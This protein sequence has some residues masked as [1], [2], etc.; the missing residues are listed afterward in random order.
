MFGWLTF[1]KSEEGGEGKFVLTTSFL[2][3]NRGGGRL[4][5]GFCRS[6]AVDAGTEGSLEGAIDVEGDAII[7]SVLEGGTWTAGSG[8]DGMR[9]PLMDARPARSLSFSFRNTVQK[10]SVSKNIRMKVQNEISNYRKA[11]KH[12]IAD[13]MQ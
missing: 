12:R 4:L 11:T 13:S 3:N 5:E 8:S 6:E 7:E 9:G 1:D 2:F 10:H